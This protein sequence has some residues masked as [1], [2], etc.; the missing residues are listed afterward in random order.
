ML[1]EEWKEET[2]KILDELELSDE[3]R[4]GIKFVFYA[5]ALERFDAE[6]ICK[7][8][9]IDLER[10]KLFEQH[11]RANGIFTEDGKVAINWLSE[12][13]AEASASLTLDSLVLI[14]LVERK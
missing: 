8:S 2:E 6:S 11:A 9:G 13:D 14:G 5:I 10:G 7:E 3:P 1:T 12:D 4:L